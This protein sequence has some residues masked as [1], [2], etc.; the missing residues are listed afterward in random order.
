MGRR[1]GKENA[2]DRILTD[3]ELRAIMGV[4]VS[5]PFPA[6]VRFLLLTAARR[7]EAAA[8]R[9]DE[10]GG[11]TWT[12]PASRNKTGEQLVRPLSKAAQEVLAGMPRL[13]AFVFSA[14]GRRGISG[15]S[16]GKRQFDQQCGVTGWTLHDLR[17][18]ARSLMSRAGIPSEHAERCLGHVLGGV[19]GTYNRY[20]YM[21]EMARAYEVLASMIERIIDPQENVL[22]MGAPLSFNAFAMTR[23]PIARSQAR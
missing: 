18:T 2:R 23:A 4:P 16:Q 14:D 8:M 6:L 5:G 22:P 11:D 13:G 9:W 21:P 19:E 10:I 17:R 7:N 3:D 12:L 20:L 15:F 1:K